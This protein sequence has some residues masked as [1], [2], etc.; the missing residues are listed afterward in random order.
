M[1]DW[2]GYWKSKSVRR[3]IIEFFREH[4]FSKIFCGL[5]E[6]YANHNKNALILEAG[7]GSGKYLRILEKKGYRCF[8]I[9]NCKESVAEA[10]KKCRNIIL[11]D[12]FKLHNYFKDKQFDIVFSQGVMEHF[13]EKETEIIYND[14]ARIGRRV[15]VFVPSN[16]SVFRLYD[17]CKDD[18]NKIFLN[19]KKIRRSLEKS[20]K[21]IEV[22]YL[23]RTFFITVMG[24]GEPKE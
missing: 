8:G 22:R 14:M 12:I 7:C 6:D 21:N 13:N 2:K 11:G 9:D 5:I 23:P 10:K 3:R 15:I 19:K 4:Y 24:Y 17:F 1:V 20:F 16:L 18:K